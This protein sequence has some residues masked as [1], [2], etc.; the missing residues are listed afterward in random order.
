L[1]KQTRSLLNELDRFLVV[2]DKTHFI[3]S[4]AA[5]VIQSAINLMQYVREQY[6]AET[7]EELERRLINSIRHQDSEKFTRSIKKL[8]ES[9]KDQ[10]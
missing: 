9:Q 1:Q 10:K 3:E 7:A 2:K 8:R 5:N 4:R 6:D